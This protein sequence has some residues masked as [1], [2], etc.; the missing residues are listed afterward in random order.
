MVVRPTDAAAAYTSAAGA[1]GR[2]GLEARD[3][4]G[5]GAFGDMVRD[6]LGRAVEQGQNSER[7]T[8]EAAVGRAELSDVVMAVNN[9]EVTLQTVVGIRDRMIQ[10]YQEIMRM[11][12]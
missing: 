5:V 4:V 6:Q 10:A 3:Q 11:P 7:V 1:S 8:A 9:A 2:P 12:V